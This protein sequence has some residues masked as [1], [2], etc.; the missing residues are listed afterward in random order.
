MALQYSNKIPLGTKIKNFNLLDPI[1]GRYK[2]LNELKSDKYNII[3]FICNHCPY[4][5]HINNELIKLSI[6]YSKQGIIFIAINSNS[7]KISP[8]D[9]PE[10]MVKVAKKLKYPFHY[11]FD[12]TQ[13]IA[14]IYN[15]ACTPDFFI[16]D[17]ND[18]LI[19]HGQL[20]D[21][22]PDNNIIVTGK[23]IRN[24]LDNKIIY[25]KK[26]NINEQKP[27]IG[28]SIKWNE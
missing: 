9:S 15:A 27:S 1:L 19:Y 11:L 25:S 22:R 23:D 21:A 20:D 4:V 17:K 8:E 28:C 14:K 5:K 2:S 10:E 18:R 26:I 16:F 3:M 13:K 24:I 6:D 12:E 7:V